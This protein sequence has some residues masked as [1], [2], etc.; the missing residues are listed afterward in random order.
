MPALQRFSWYSLSWKSPYFNI[1][2]RRWLLWI[3]CLRLLRSG[4]FEEI[5]IHLLILHM[6]YVFGGAERTTAN[7]L[8]H[9]DRGRIGAITLVAPAALKPFLPATYDRF[10]DSASYWLEPGFT[11]PGV[12]RRDARA[13]GELLRILAPDVA[14]GMMHYASAL[15]VF[16]VRLAGLQTRTVASYRGPFY[17]YLCRYEHDSRRRQFLQTVAAETASLA[18]RVIVPS[19]GVA[20]ELQQRFMTP[21]SQVAVIPNGIDLAEVMDAAQAAVPELTDLAQDGMPVLCAIARLA[22]EKNIGLL[23]E[24]FRRIRTSQPAVLLIIGEGPEQGALEAQITAWGLTGAVRFLG[25]RANVYPYLRRA[26]V[27]IHTC[28]FEGFGYTMLE[29]LAC[30]AA[31]VATDCPY[32]P[33][34]VLDHGRCGLLVPMDDPDALAGAVL[35]LLADPALRRMLA[36]RGLERAKQLS[37]Q[38]MADAYATELLALVGASSQAESP[39]RDRVTP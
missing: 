36:A 31:V 29:A 21:A 24:A 33:R 3:W 34:E 4:N 27:F 35:R 22:P 11:A 14:L 39:I 23:L 1:S 30:G 7:L 5:L 6:A 9:L 25:R 8:T 20:D 12:L 19:Q 38:C 13:F 2:S 15:V 37:A 10:I 32:G 28:H 17:E 18:D 26:D 16:G